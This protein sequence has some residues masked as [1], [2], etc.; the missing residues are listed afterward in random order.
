LVATAIAAVATAIV[1]ATADAATTRADYAAQANPVC[2]RAQQPVDQAIRTYLN[3]LRKQGQGTGR[4]K[5]TKETA[6][7]TV[8]FGR[9]I[10]AVYSSVTAGLRAIPPAPGDEQT[11]ASWLQARDDARI[12]VDA[13]V[14]AYK[15]RHLRQARH[16]DKLNRAAI[17]Q[18]NTA[19]RS[20]GLQVECTPDDGNL[21]EFDPL[22]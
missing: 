21:F 18:A 11:V 9:R 14:R 4:I 17:A 1:S 10:S 8:R 20:L 6:G 12:S 19:G 15:K 3:A 7:P 2:A 16:L 13:V 5:V 22:R